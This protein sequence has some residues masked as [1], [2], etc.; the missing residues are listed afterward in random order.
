LG[1]E[2][3]RLRELPSSLFELKNLQY[4]HLSRN[5]L[6]RI[7]KDLQRLSRLRKLDLR[8]NDLTELCEVL[9]RFRNL[10]RLDV[11]KNRI[12]RI[13]SQ[14]SRL[15]SLVDLN[16]DNNCLIDLPAELSRTRGSLKFL[17]LAN[18]SLRLS[19]DDYEENNEAS[20]VLRKLRPT[21]IQL[22]IKGNKRVEPGVMDLHEWA[23]SEWIELNDAAS[24]LKKSISLRHSR[25]VEK[26]LKRF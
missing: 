12:D 16:L 11:S 24:E 2:G 25:N 3:N 13:S 26:G 8:D 9:C 6:T 10:R 23:N 19:L 18:N 7:P 15:V 17:G 20:R 21:L 1:L 22:R 14:I 4:L 5:Q